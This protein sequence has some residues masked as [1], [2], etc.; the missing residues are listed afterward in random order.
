MFATL[1]VVQTSLFV[2]GTIEGFS[3]SGNHMLVNLSQ[4]LRVPPRAQLLIESE[5][6]NFDQEELWTEDSQQEKRK[7]TSVDAQRK[8]KQHH[9][10]DD[11]KQFQVEPCTEGG[12]MQPLAAS[13][14]ARSRISRDDPH[15]DNDLWIDELDCY[16]QKEH[17]SNCPTSSMLGNLKIRRST[18]SRF[19]TRQLKC[20]EGVEK[21]A[22]QFK[23]NYREV[24]R[25]VRDAVYWLKR[26]WMVVKHG[27]IASYFALERLVQAVQGAVKVKNSYSCKRQECLRMI[28]WCF[29]L[30]PD[31]LRRNWNLFDPDRLL[32]E[33]LLYSSKKVGG[34]LGIAGEFRKWERKE[35]YIDCRQDRERGAMVYEDEYVI[36]H[37][38]ARYGPVD[39]YLQLG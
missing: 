19:H 18:K 15:R 34:L 27:K 37:F 10:S 13:P 7:T 12:E 21:I 39:A 24:V 22:E 5:E 30:G 6:E 8:P 28:V 25:T 1:N 38:E 2:Q 11:P 17:R 36:N 20:L 32:H 16:L 33:G 3:Y 31:R 26:A 35:G 14:V 9:S 4:V 29:V 23:V